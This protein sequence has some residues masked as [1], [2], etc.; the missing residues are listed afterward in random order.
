MSEVSLSFQ[1]KPLIT[2]ISELSRENKKFGKLV[3][4]LPTFLRTLSVNL[5][6]YW[7]FWV[8]IAAHRLSLVAETEGCSSVVARGLL[9]VVASLVVEHRL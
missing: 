8:F 9:V 7:L 1:G 4:S 3:P 5:F 6:V 2:M